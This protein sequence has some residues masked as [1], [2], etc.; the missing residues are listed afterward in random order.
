MHVPK[1]CII[2]SSFLS[3]S[4]C[5]NCYYLVSKNWGNTY[6]VLCLF[7]GSVYLFLSWGFC[8]L[9]HHTF[10]HSQ[11]LYLCARTDFHQAHLIATSYWEMCTFF[12]TWWVA[13][14]FSNELR[15]MAETDTRSDAIL[16]DVEPQEL[17]CCLT[18]KWKHMSSTLHMLRIKDSSLEDRERDPGLF[19]RK[20]ESV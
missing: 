3:A 12:Q 15:T 18:I 13:R 19:L 8:L 14:L 20:I 17:I 1:M 9:Y 6:I 5:F 11:H 7:G 4:N 16:R 10:H 2:P